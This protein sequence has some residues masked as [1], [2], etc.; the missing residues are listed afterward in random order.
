MAEKEL[1]K[2]AHLLVGGKPLSFKSYPDGSMN[3]ITSIGQKC[4]FTKAQVEA[5][6][7]KL[8]MKE[9]QTQAKK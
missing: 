7:M 6:G 9:K 8:T 2:I 5:A 1:D 3:V 4:H